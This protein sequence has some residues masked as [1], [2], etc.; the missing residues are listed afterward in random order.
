MKKEDLSCFSSACNAAEKAALRLVGIAEQNTFGLKTKLRKK[1]FDSTVIAEVISRLLNQNLISDTR[2]AEL[3][4]RSRLLTRKKLSPFSLRVS[5]GRKGIDHRSSQKAMQEVLD[6]ETEY[7]LLVNYIEKSSFSESE[8][9]RNIK[10]QLKKE[11]FS[12]DVLDEYYS[13]L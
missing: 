10:S 11:G 2:Y 1:G 12:S 3:W 5:L 7:S 8:T 4:L 6:F 13:V 9:T